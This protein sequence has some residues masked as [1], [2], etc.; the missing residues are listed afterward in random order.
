M[1]IVQLEA[2]IA[3]K[4]EE[5]KQLELDKELRQEELAEAKDCAKRSG[6][7]VEKL[8]KQKAEQK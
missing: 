3:Q 5:L 2:R 1:F 7:Q 4:D 8:K 6:E